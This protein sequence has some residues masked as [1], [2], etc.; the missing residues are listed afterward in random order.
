MRL[1]CVASALLTLNPL[2]CSWVTNPLNQANGDH[3]Q[4]VKRHPLLCSK[5][6]GS[7]LPTRALHRDIGVI[8][9]L[10]IEC[11]RRWLLV[12]SPGGLIF[13]PSPQGENDRR[14]KPGQP[15]A[16]MTPLS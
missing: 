12:D 13:L 2:L 11:R 5:C 8:E 14:E 7:L 3:M 15:P 1:H 16:K 4:T 10:C 6:D 9:Y